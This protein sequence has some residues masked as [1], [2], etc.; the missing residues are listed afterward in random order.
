MLGSAR[1]AAPDAEPPAAQPA[2]KPD[3][4]PRVAIS[5]SKE[6]T[7]ITGPLRKDGYVNYIAALNELA[8]KGVTPENNASVLLWQAVGPKGPQELDPEYSAELFKLLGIATPPQ[9]G[10][11]FVSFDAFVRPQLGKDPAENE[12]IWNQLELAMSRPWSDDECPLVAKWLKANDGPLKLIVEASHRPRRYDPAPFDEQGT[13]IDVLLPGAQQ[14]REFARALTSRAMQRASSGKLDAAWDDLLACH[15]LARLIGQGQTVVDELVCYAIDHLACTADQGL[16]QHS[17]LTSAQALKIRADLEKLPPLPSTVD[18]IDVAERYLV[19]DSTAR[20]AREGVQAFGTL[21]DGQPIENKSGLAKMLLS[22]ADNSIDWDV[23][24]RS[25]NA[26]FDR[27]V[28]AWRKPTREERVQAI[29]AIDADIRVRTAKF[30]TDLWRAILN[31]RQVL[32]QSA[33]DVMIGVMMPA[34]L[35]VGNAVDNAHVRFDLI[36][37]GFALAAYRADRGAYPATLADLA[38]KYIGQIPPD[39][40]AAGDLHYQISANGYVLYSIGMNQRDD[41][42]QTFEEHDDGVD[43]DDLVVRVPALA[44]PAA[45]P[46][47]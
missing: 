2:N 47:Q 32:T 34:L 1:A 8:S 18:R 16:L 35:Q 28:E 25:D 6:T 29:A 14:S 39:L 38:P 33:S 13:V 36:R 10:D 17:K 23:V 5:I 42:G 20:I 24:L 30:R 22:I 43:A 19:L 31:P 3:E 9:Q 44:K 41:E 45:K 12:K 26:W 4:K 7:W 15:R 11:Y 46:E 37:L 21:T 40:Y 27:L